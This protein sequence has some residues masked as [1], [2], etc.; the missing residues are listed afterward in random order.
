MYVFLSGSNVKKKDQ[1]F[2]AVRRVGLKIVGMQGREC[3]DE[4]EVRALQKLSIQRKERMS[5]LYDKNKVL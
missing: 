1:K 4:E 3:T 2:L 5:M